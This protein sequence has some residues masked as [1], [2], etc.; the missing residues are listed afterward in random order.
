M[1]PQSAEWERI[2]ELLSVAAE[3]PPEQRRVWLRETGEPADLLARIESLLTAYEAEPDFLELETLD[4]EPAVS[5]KLGPWI[6][7]REIGQGGMGRVFEAVHEDPT[8]SRRVALKVVGARRMLPG[9]IESFL[10]ERAI[11]ALLE[12]PAIARLYDTGSSPS[13]LPYFAMEY[14]DGIPFDSWLAKE[15]PPLRKRVELLAAIT[16]A[17]EHAHRI[18]VAHGDLKPSNI[19]ITAKGEP[20]LVDFGIARNWTDSDAGHLPLLTPAH[21]SPEQLAG[22]PI[23]AASDIYQMGLLLRLAAPEG[24][25]ELAAIATRCLAETAEQR[26]AS[27]SAL[28]ED[29]LAW[30]AHRP[31]SAVENSSVYLLRKFVRRRPLAAA[32]V[33]ALFLG[34]GGTG[35]QGYRAEMHRREAQRQFEETR[36]FSRALLAS[37]PSLPASAQ[38]AIVESTTK[39]LES[40]SLNQQNDPTLQLELSYAWRSLGNVQGLPTAKNLG[41]RESAARSY[42]RATVLAESARDA[43]LPEAIAMLATLYANAARVEA[44]RDRESDAEAFTNKLQALLPGLEERGPS[45]DLANALAELAYL[46]GRKHPDQAMVLYARSVEM[47]DRA[48][49]LGSPPKAFALKRWGALLLRKG[50]LDGGIARYRQALAIERTQGATPMDLSFTLSDLGLA[51]RQQKRYPEAESYYRETL[52]IREKAHADDPADVRVAKSLATTCWRLGWVYADAGRPLDA[53]PLGRRAVSMYE[54]MALPP[55]DSS[56]NVLDLAIAQVYLAEFLTIAAAQGRR[57]LPEIQA[58]AGR[59]P[60]VQQLLQ[61]AARAL[62]R[63]PN[64]A[65]AQELAAMGIGRNSKAPKEPKQ[66]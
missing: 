55:H 57:N 28:H 61:S 66:P 2:T 42:A 1:T 62:A 41:D 8:L 65:L 45:V 9:L 17:V 50:D 3:L 26:Y 31:V 21:A 15:Q 25:A 27:A 33:A 64:D 23:G 51:C 37:I 10:Q 58:L 38:R 11:L 29:L 5:D 18:F 32:L 40:A 44:A 59:M 43:G 39:L 54:P 12:H 48:G 49:D 34:M 13:G 47:F 35:W 7:Q 46:R 14:V 52:A 22:H 24:D 4:P 60:E 36:R 53:I 20:R 6:I 63:Y 19:L 30:L 56:S 16:D